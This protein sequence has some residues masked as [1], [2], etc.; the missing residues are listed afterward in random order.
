[1]SVSTQL[2]CSSS[3]SSYA[4]TWLSWGLYVRQ[5]AP[6]YNQLWLLN[7]LYAFHQGCSVDLY[8]QPPFKIQCPRMILCSLSWFHLYYVTS[9]SRAHL[10]L[11]KSPIR[12]FCWYGFIFTNYLRV[13][14]Y[15]SLHMDVSKQLTYSL[16]RIISRHDIP[17][18]CFNWSLYY[19]SY[20]FQ[21]VFISYL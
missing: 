9:C 5:N 10:G 16:A 4:S 21:C 14:N 7:P 12:S 1:M 6:H 15:Y 13:L 17:L 8:Y 3:S 19:T 2:P 11:M 18:K 20:A